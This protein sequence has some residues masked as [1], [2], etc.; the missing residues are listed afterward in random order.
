MPPLRQL[1]WAG[2]IILATIIVF[3]FVLHGTAF[4][5]G[6]QS[7]LI[8]ASESPFWASFA[9]R[10]GDIGPGD[11]SAEEEAGYIRN[12]RYFQGHVDV[13]RLGVDHDFCRLVGAGAGA[14]GAGA[15]AKE[16]L[17]LACALAGTDG[18]SSVSFATEKQSQGFRISRDD[19]MRDVTGDGRADYCRILKTG[20]R[21]WEALCRE[22]TDTG[23]AKKD[24]VDPDP[25]KTIKE[26]L[27]FYNGC[28]WWFRFAD[29]MVDYCDQLAISH[30][31]GVSMDEADVKR[32][33]DM[34]TCNIDGLELNGKQFMRIGEK[35]TLEFGDK[36]RM[37][38]VRAFSLWVKFDEFT[39]NTHIFDFGNGAGKDNVWLG[40]TKPAEETAADLAP[41]MCE[42]TV[43]AWPSG[44]QA[45]VEQTPQEYMKT[46]DA[47]VDEYEC[48]GG[49][50]ESQFEAGKARGLPKKR[51]DMIYEVWDKTQR[52]MRIKVPNAFELGRWT[53]VAIT[54]KDT[55]S[56]RPDINVW[57]DGR[58]MFSKE[59]GFLPQTDYMSRN[60]IGKS[61]W[62][63]VISQYSDKDELFKGRIFDFRAYAEPID[64]APIYAWGKR[65][66]RGDKN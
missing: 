33:Q 39:N 64:V 54:A 60:Y 12:I 50:K 15:A 8:N 43:P 10:R 16:D 48:T 61:N 63:D 22:A 59:A 53:H 34:D 11:A 58:V 46:S 35:K 28:L 1:F 2:L 23:F 66:L 30:A 20:E 7:G 38:G 14:A 62:S 52:V 29:D 49:A 26:L 36:I 9:P 55:K 40:I 45:P 32:I 57:I 65:L 13:Q 6:F 47:N 4:K 19:Y 25:P 56:F 17:Q 27:N 37:R 5:E 44:P 31:G 24:T 21:Q 3:E 18:L 51:A 42:S 41:S